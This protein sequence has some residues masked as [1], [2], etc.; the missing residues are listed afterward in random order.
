ML[1]FY[2]NDTYLLS[3]KVV[4][5]FMVNYPLKTGIYQNAGILSV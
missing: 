2:K 4:P 3:T 5:T 1:A